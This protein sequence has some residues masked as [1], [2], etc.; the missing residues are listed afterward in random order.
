MKRLLPV[1]LLSPL[2]SG[3]AVFSVA[4]TA[5][6]V[7]GTATATG[8]KTAGAVIAAPFKM[9]GDS[10]AEKDEGPGSGEG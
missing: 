7:T 3:C 6:K 4:A 5:V 9:I 8:I 2:L 10:E 1:L